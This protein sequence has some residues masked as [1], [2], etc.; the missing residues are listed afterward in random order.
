ML[1]KLTEKVG[2]DVLGIELNLYQLA[3]TPK[4]TEFAPMHFLNA[5]THATGYFIAFAY[6]LPSEGVQKAYSDTD[7]LMERQVQT[8]RTIS[9]RLKAGRTRDEII[10]EIRNT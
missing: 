3:K 10:L 9:Q 6:F 8:L 7:K 2:A 4:G 5:A 1:A